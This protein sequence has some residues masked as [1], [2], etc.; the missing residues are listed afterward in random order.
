MHQNLQRQTETQLAQHTQA[1]IKAEHALQRETEMH[2]KLQRQTERH[3][4]LQRQT[5]EKQRQL[6][7]QLAQHT[8]TQLEAEHALQRKIIEHQN[9]QTQLEEQLAQHTQAQVKT[10]YALQRKMI[11]HQNS[12]TQLEEQLAQHTQ[13]QVKTEY[14]LQKETEMHQKLQR[15]TEE[16][17]RQLEAQLVQHTQAQVKAENELQRKF[18][19]H[20][21]LQTQLERQL[22]QHTQTQIK[23]E[24]ALQRET[25]MHQ[26]LQRQTE[27][28]QRQLEAQLT[29]YKQIQLEAK[30]AQELK[31]Q[32]ERQ[33]KELEKTHTE[34]TR[35][36]LET[37]KR[38]TIMVLQKLQSR[39]Q[40]K[41]PKHRATHPKK[42]KK[43]PVS[44]DIS[45]QRAKCDSL[46]ESIEHPVRS[47]WDF[48]KSEEPKIT[49]TIHTL[50]SES[51]KSCDDQIVMQWTT[52]K[53]LKKSSEQQTRS[54]W[55]PITSKTFEIAEQ[56]SSSSLEEVRYGGSSIS[57]ESINF[58]QV[59]IIPEL[60]PDIPISFFLRFISDPHQ[61]NTRTSQISELEFLV[62][63]KTP[64]VI[65]TFISKKEMNDAKDAL[66]THLK[67]SLPYKLMSN[68]L[69]KEPKL[70]LLQ[71]EDKPAYE[72]SLP[73]T[74]KCVPTGANIYLTYLGECNQTMPHGAR[75]N[76]KYK[77]KVIIAHSTTLKC[78]TALAQWVV[79]LTGKDF[80]ELLTLLELRDFKKNKLIPVNS[81]IYHKNN[82]TLAHDITTQASKIT[83]TCNTYISN[84][85][86]LV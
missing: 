38:N 28:K 40:E 62:L 54:Q 83:K 76:T 34:S 85:S 86:M 3:Q 5:E 80:G 35:Q 32:L 75:K 69:D 51:S 58:E 19:E 30:A 21:N 44:D 29:Q 2:Q 78:H 42:Y 24:H 73:I 84:K 46:S 60:N 6:E 14:A 43:M 52:P 67:E 55:S 36:Q 48:S 65:G 68:P 72:M 25:E 31:E 39:L 59:A 77:L 79:N 18:I 26:K 37:Q 10:E 12:Q 22:A 57:L 71:L 27:E 47:K 82:Y 74:Q 70:G 45:L 49:T 64:T 7:A 56:S 53:K 50:C 63:K 9:L 20:Q 16:K 13:A 11:E 4:K 61:Q 41:E 66:T 17:Q 33:L 15:Q 23:T 81:S 1:Q 8:Q